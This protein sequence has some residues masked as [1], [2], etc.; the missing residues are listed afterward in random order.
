MNYRP[1]RL[2]HCDRVFGLKDISSHINAFDTGL[3][4]VERILQ[5]LFFRNFFP[6]C[7]DNWN[8]NTFSDLFEVF[9]KICFYNVRSVLLDNSSRVGEVF[10]GVEI[11]VS[12]AFTFNFFLQIS[13]DSGNTKN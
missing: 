5:R 3:Y 13:S 9:T 4:S 8:L 2:Y 11:R 6:S 7:D 12:F 10:S 1:Y